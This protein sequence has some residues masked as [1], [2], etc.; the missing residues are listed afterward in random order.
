MKTT[1]EF[2][3]EQISRLEIKHR[4]RGIR[5][6]VKPGAIVLTE[7]SADYVITAINSGV[8]HLRNLDSIPVS[9]IC[10]NLT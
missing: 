3:L 1:L 5:V 8:K 10:R 6:R 2:K 7:E 4:I 9:R